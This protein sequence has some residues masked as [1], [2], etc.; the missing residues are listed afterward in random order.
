MLSG[1]GQQG[2]RIAVQLLFGFS[3]M[4]HC[5]H[6]KHHPLVTG[7]QVVQKFLTFLALLLKVIRDNCGEV[8]VLILFSLPVC[9]IGFDTK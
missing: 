1:S 6:R 9:D 8:I 2:F 7:C 4:H 5:Q 3:G